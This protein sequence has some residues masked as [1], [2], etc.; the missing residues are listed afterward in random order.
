MK[1]STRLCNVSKRQ[2]LRREGIRPGFEKNRRSGEELARPSTRCNLTVALRWL[3]QPRTRTWTQV[4][5]TKR[6]KN[7][8]GPAPPHVGARHRDAAC[9]RAQDLAT[10][11]LPHLGSDARLQFQSVRSGGT[12]LERAALGLSLARPETPMHSRCARRR[13]GRTAG[14]CERIAPRDAARMW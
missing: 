9:T 10:C 14:C 3:V 11:A 12:G 4:L 13:I 8:P 5:S 6:H 7:A 2:A 1:D